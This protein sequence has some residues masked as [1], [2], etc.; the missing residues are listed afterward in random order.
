VPHGE[1]SSY[2]VNVHPVYAME[3]CATGEMFE[4]CS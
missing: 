2:V 4:I 1:F 3:V